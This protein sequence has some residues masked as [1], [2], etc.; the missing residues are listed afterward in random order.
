MIRLGIRVRTAD[1][2]LAYALLEPVLAAGAEEVDA[3]DTVEYALY[4][5]ELPS[6]A[7]LRALAGDTIIGVRREPVAAGWE[8][9]W[10]AHL[11]RAVV[12]A[13]AVRPPWVAGEP[14]DLVIDP[15][16]TFGA[17]GHPTTR[18]C[19]ELL[20]EP[21]RGPAIGPAAAGR[22]RGRSRPLP[23]GPLADWGCGSGVLA[24]AAARLGF[25]PVGAI[26]VDADA[27][28]LAR[29][30]AAANAVAVD[31][32]AGDLEAR[33]AAGVDGRREPHAAA[34]GVAGARARARAADRV[35]IPRRARP[36]G[37]PRRSG[38]SSASAARRDGWAAIVLERA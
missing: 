23:R 11:G 19:L 31:V 2:E 24:I 9:A 33:R 27:A 28:A 14:G 4:G 38:S 15:G 16:A 25:A 6:E 20:Q 5:D 17:A 3:G 18:L 12:G 37:W 22:A 36:T 7:E 10:H 8:R 30:N 29:A 32:V 35:G 1:A 26:E 21:A 34:A 13:L